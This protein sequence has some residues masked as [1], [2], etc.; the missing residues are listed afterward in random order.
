MGILRQRMISCCGLFAWLGCG[1][2][3]GEL[4]VRVNKLL[5]DEVCQAEDQEE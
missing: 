5:I 2:V 4:R 1:R 3:R